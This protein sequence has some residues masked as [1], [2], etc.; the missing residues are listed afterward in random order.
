FEARFGD[1][2]L[3]GGPGNAKLIGGVGEDHFV[4]GDGQ[5]DIISGPGENTIE[6]T[7]GTN[8]VSVTHRAQTIIIKRTGFFQQIHG[9]VAGQI[10]LT[11]WVGLGP[12][13]TRAKDGNVIV[14]AGTERAIFF[15]AELADIR[16]AIMID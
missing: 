8:Q 1:N 6:I 2:Y 13:S 11:D 9:F 4:S 15:D 14:S 16:G 5:N 12:I 7:G 10:Y 3:H